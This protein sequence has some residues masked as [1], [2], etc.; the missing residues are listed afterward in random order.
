VISSKRID[1][2][3]V[4]SNV[5]HQL[6]VL[7]VG[8]DEEGLVLREE[9][10]GVED[11]SRLPN[12]KFIVLNSYPKVTEVNQI[13]QELIGENQCSINVLALD[14]RTTLIDEAARRE[15]IFAMAFPTLYP[16]GLANFN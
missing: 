9:V 13:L 12:F 10:L 4:D 3:L 1:Q 11:D 16:N 6:L 7:N 8:D 5:S 2:L 15:Q 14:I